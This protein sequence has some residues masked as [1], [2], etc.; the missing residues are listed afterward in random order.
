M[1]DWSEFI[2]TQTGVI[3]QKIAECKRGISDNPGTLDDELTA[4]RRFEL[5]LA[6]LEESL[7]RIKQGTYSSCSC[8]GKI[9]RERLVAMPTAK[10][11]MTC[12]GSR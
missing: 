6:A 10:T 1:N 5:S 3:N 7:I 2:K 11:C 9:S 4:R 8:G 12:N